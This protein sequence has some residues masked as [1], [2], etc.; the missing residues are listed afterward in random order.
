M[1]INKIKEQNPGLT[2]VENKICRF[3]SDISDE[4]RKK[5]DNLTF[6]EY[7]NIVNS[8]INDNSNLNTELSTKLEEDGSLKTGEDIT[9]GITLR[10][11]GNTIT[12]NYSED[13]CA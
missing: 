2:N 3:F 11:S 6:I 1:I 5:I 13:P 9:R 8:F 10:Y 7:E 4:E 12:L